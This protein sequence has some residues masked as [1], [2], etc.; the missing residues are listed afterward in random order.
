MSKP[1][2][3]TLLKKRGKHE[4]KL[5][6]MKQCDSAGL[7]DCGGGGSGSSSP[8][9]VVPIYAGDEPVSSP[10]PITPTP[11]SPVYAPQV[12]PIMAMDASWPMTINDTNK[13]SCPQLAKAIDD[14]KYLL[15][16]MK[17]SFSAREP[18]E[19]WLAYAEDRYNNSCPLMANPST[20]EVPDVLNPSPGNQV[21]D[22]LTDDPTTDNPPITSTNN[23]PTVETTNSTPTTDDPD[24]IKT[25][26]A[27]VILP[28]QI[29]GGG[30]GGSASGSGESLPSL[31]KK[32]WYWIVL[33]GVGV[34]GFLTF[35][36]P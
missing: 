12:L 36:K 33:A 20:P 32:N 10:A 13:M 2:G 30:G 17:M 21:P 7:D 9:P 26:T 29:P 23:V 25:V 5:H 1:L 16:H 22:V 8:A 11:E 27:P 15:T 24:A 3:S 19:Q 31:A 18:H 4:P 14:E 34:A 35:K 6:F 28:Y